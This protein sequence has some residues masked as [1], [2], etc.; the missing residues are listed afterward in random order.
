MLLVS[1]ATATVRQHAGHPHLG[2]LMRPGN[3]NVPTL[4]YWAADNGAFTGFDADAF[5]AMLGRLPRTAKWVAAPD[6]VGD[7]RATEV[8]FAEWSPR[9]RELGF[10]VAYVLQDGCERIP[11]ADCLFVGGTTDYK[12]SRQA[13]TWMREAKRRGMLVHVGRVNSVRR[14]RWAYDNGA[15]SI[16]GTSV[17]MFPDRWLLWTLRHMQALHSQ[18]SIPALDGVKARAA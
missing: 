11:D 17:S 13:A 8:L 5:I 2:Q 16:D 9:I 3:G 1:G 15:D 6:V 7:W 18:L 14:M 4:P 12:L 10:P